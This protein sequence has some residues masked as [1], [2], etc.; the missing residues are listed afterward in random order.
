[1]NL[2]NYTIRTLLKVTAF[3]VIFTLLVFTLIFLNQQR[4]SQHQRK[5]LISLEHLYQQN[6]LLKQIKDNFIFR[7]IRSEQL[8]RLGYSKST[9]QHDSLIKV[10]KENLKQI[11]NH[12]S[13]DQIDLIGQQL[14]IYNKKFYGV[15]ELVQKRGFKDF[16]IEGELR[17]KI[18][19]VETTV[20]QYKDYRLKSHMLM[21]RRHEKDY[22]IR[23]DIAYLDKFNN[24]LQQTLAYLNPSVLA[25]MKTIT[26]LNEYGK[27]F[28]NYVNIDRAIGDE[29]SGAVSDLNKISEE[30]AFTINEALE[31]L[32]KQINS[33]ANR[34]YLNMLVL[35][36]IV[37]L[38]TL[39][40][41]TKVGK[42]ITKNL[43][44]IQKVLGRMGKG[45]IPDAIKIK[46]KDELSGIELSINDLST[47]LRNTRDFAIQ[48]GN[49][50][51]YSEVNVFGNTGELGT[52]LLEMRKKLMEVAKER[53]R[54]LHENEQRNWLNESLAKVSDILRVKYES[55]SELCFQFIRFV[56]QKT[57]AL[58][59]GVF[60]VQENNNK[61]YIELITSYALDRRKYIN[62]TLD[63]HEG[64]PGACIFEKDT[65]F[66]TDI[67]KD[68]IH[69]TTGLGHSNPSCI[70]LAP[71]ITDMNEVLG[72]IE[73]ASFKVLDS[74]Q[75]DFIRKACISLAS[76]IKFNEMIRI[77]E[78]IIEEM[79]QKNHELQANEE[80]LRQNMEEL[81]SIREDMERR[82]EELSREI[83]EL[84]KIINGCEGSDIFPK[85]IMRPVT[86]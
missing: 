59:G 62:K 77:N 17:A 64:L 36:A 66:I 4:N 49:G 5:A 45:E 60:L 74:T 69:I 71:L 54:N 56:A 48:V 33:N 81:K 40:I 34:V 72:C 29:S 47:A 8:Y 15:I 22:I 84:K 23:K 52:K 20:E 83:N 32:T 37:S 19:A 26:L 21:L 14:I 38:L 30:L 25:N 78:Q 79:K 68:Y 24:E 41:I 7:D 80:E 75:Q 39:Y 43:K 73:I 6:L 9:L 82:E 10:C 63:I 76:A 28:N 50:N 44:L 2:R 11:G 85:S 70:M 51:F 16:G 58:Q 67:P 35:I 57:D 42:H 65:I 27:L 13:Y 18:H 12:Y 61:K 3:V 86:N 31:E 1:M 55:T 46:G 53:E